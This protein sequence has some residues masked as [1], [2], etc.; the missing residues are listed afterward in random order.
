MPQTMI[1]AQGNGLLADYGESVGRPD[2]LSGEVR[3]VRGVAG[4][5]HDHELS[6]RPDTLEFPRVP[7]GGLK[8]KASVHHNPGDGGQRGG[9]AK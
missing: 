4:V 3:V 2:E 8:V 7:D 6:L 5:V 1:V 9:V